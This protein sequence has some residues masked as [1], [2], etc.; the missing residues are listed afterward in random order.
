MIK[1]GKP[2]LPTGANKASDDGGNDPSAI[3][4]DAPPTIPV[5]A[6]VEDT[7]NNPAAPT[8]LS[9]SDRDAEADLSRME[10]NREFAPPTPPLHG[11]ASAKTGGDNGDNDDTTLVHSDDVVAERVGVVEVVKESK[12]SVASATTAAT[13]ADADADADVT[14]NITQQTPHFPPRFS[15]ASTYNAD[16]PEFEH[17]KN[18]YNNEETVPLP[19]KE[20]I[21]ELL[22]LDEKIQD[23][24]KRIDMTDDIE[25]IKKLSDEGDKLETASKERHE[26]H[27]KLEAEARRINNARYMAEQASRYWLKDK[28]DLK[29]Y[30][31]WKIILK[32]IEKIFPHSAEM[33]SAEANTDA[34]GNGGATVCK[35]LLKTLPAPRKARRGRVTIP[36]DNRLRQKRDWQ[37]ISENT[38]KFY[39]QGES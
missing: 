3:Y 23:I 35:K 20:S 8:L 25:E 27:K 39:L 11:P 36:K 16:D 21:E 37:Y 19:S 22:Q 32:M 2:T 33:T 12:I 24:V 6:T 38:F 7:T 17:V 26:Q 5:D 30:G 18:L 15:I 29:K 13:I 34:D 31:E 9:R 4:V 14:M 10:D 1:N 28:R